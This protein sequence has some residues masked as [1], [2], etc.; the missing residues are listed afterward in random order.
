[1]NQ[2]TPAVYQRVGSRQGDCRQKPYLT[3]PRKRFLSVAHVWRSFPCSSSYAAGAHLNYC[4]Y[5]LY[6]AIPCRASSA[7]TSIG[8]AGGDTL[9]GRQCCNRGLQFGE[10]LIR[11]LGVALLIVQQSGLGFRY[12]GRTNPDFP[13]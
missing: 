1:M 11:D 12:S 4:F 9:C 5:I 3:A 10:G 2:I 7:G 8:S 6:I 13:P